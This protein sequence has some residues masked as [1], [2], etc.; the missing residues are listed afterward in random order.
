[1]LF[2]D[3]VCY[4]SVSWL[5]DWILF[6]VIICRSCVHL[7]SEFPHTSVFLIVN[8]QHVEYLGFAIGASPMF[9]RADSVTLNTPHTTE[10]SEKII[11]RSTKINRTLP[12]IV[13]RGEIC[14]KL[15]WLS[16]NQLCSSLGLELMVKLRTLCLYIYFESWSSRLWKGEL[17]FRRGFWCLA[18][19]NALCQ[20]ANQSR[21]CLSEGGTL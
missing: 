18:N 12:R 17:Y 16:V 9:F 11:F 1:M 4:A 20:L 6:I 19:H 14:P 21:L 15:P 3:C 8:I 10:K 5:S 2:H 7:S 13:G